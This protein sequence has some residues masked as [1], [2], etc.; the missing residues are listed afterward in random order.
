MKQRSLLLFE[1]SIQINVEKISICS[2][3]IKEIEIDYCHWFEPSCTETGR[4]ESYWELIPKLQ[5]LS[6]DMCEK[7]DYTC[8]YTFEKN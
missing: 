7:L 5:S 2:A 4:F 1:E 8:M 6:E 3:D